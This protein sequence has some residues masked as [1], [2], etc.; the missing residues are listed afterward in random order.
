MNGVAWAVG[1]A[2]VASLNKG[3]PES[4]AGFD[5]GSFAAAMATVDLTNVFPAPL[6]AETLK[7]PSNMGGPALGALARQLDTLGRH[8]VEAQTLSAQMAGAWAS[9][10][11]TPELAI[12]MH[13]QARAT[14][15]YNMGVMWGAKLVGLTAGALRQLVTAT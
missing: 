7:A 2:S 15:S 8:R 10:I 6:G 14:A 12:S 3:L 11:D 4:P 13:R 1:A 9:G 5:R